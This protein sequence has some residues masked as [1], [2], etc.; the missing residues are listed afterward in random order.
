LEEQFKGKNV[1]IIAAG[2][3]LDKNIHLLQNKPKNSIILATG[4]IHRKLEKLGIK[5]DYTIMADA[6]KII[7]SQVDNLAD[8]SF[9]MLL[10]STVY[11]G[12]GKAVA[13]DKYLICQNDY[14]EAYQH[15]KERGYQMYRSGGSVTTIALDVSIRLGAS[16]IVFLGADLANTNN[17]THASDTS[18]L[19]VMGT[20]GLIPVPSIDG[21][22]VYS[23]RILCMYREWIEK[24]LKQATDIEFVDAT[25]GGALIKGTRI[26][27]LQEIIHEISC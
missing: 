14:H 27:T 5:P 10:L 9:P 8:Y 11:R 24:R 2:P 25:E 3:S 1:F 17:L 13:G 16:R 19:R 15:A 4:T 7:M 21:G 20:E 22:I 6:Q 26:C 18:F 23:T 12:V